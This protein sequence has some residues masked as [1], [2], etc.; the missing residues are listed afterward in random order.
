MSLSNDR[1]HRAVRLRWGFLDEFIP[2]PW[3]HRDEP[4]LHDLEKSALAMN[5]PLEVVVGSAPGWSEPWSRARL[6]WVERDP[7]GWKNWLVGE[8]GTVIDEADVQRARLSVRLH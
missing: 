7:N 8:D 3:V 2:A 1:L 6:A 5:V 4:T